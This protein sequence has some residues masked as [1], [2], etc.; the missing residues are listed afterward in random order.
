MTREELD[1][2]LKELVLPET[3]VDR[4]LEIVKAIQEDKDASISKY[5]ELV[6]NTAKLQE[7]YKKLQGT[8]VEEFFNNGVECE[9]EKEVVDTSNPNEEPEPIPSYD[10]VVNELLGE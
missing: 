7:D 1:T 4:G 5:E 6:S 8:K 9:P 10:E 3:T 2:L